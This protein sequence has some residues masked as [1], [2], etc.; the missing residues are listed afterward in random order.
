MQKN[1]IRPVVVI[2]QPKYALAMKTLLNLSMSCA[3]RL[4]RSTTTL[5]SSPFMR[6]LVTCGFSRPQASASLSFHHLHS[7]PPPPTFPSLNFQFPFICPIRVLA[8][9]FQ[10]KVERRITVNHWSA[11]SFIPSSLQPLPGEWNYHQI[12][13]SLGLSQ[14]RP[15]SSPCRKTNFK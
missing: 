5:P 10:I 8:F 4:G 2:L 6:P 13:N 1:E 7:A 12:T 9:I 11:D 15:I 3:P 14:H